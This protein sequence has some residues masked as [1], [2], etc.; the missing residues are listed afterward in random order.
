MDLSHWVKKVKSSMA[1]SPPV[2]NLLP[3]NV[4]SII[5]WGTPTFVRL[6]IICKHVI[7]SNI[8]QGF[9]FISHFRFTDSNG[10]D[11]WRSS[12]V[13]AEH[14]SSP[15][16]LYIYGVAVLPLEAEL[17]SVS[18]LLYSRRAV[19]FPALAM[20]YCCHEQYISCSCHDILLP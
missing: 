4:V 6:V 9:N 19:I 10:T 2:E 16:H 15:L 17:N 1:R 11:L 5:N 20:I 8:V 3:Q 7:S 18:L 14:N 12:L 13:K